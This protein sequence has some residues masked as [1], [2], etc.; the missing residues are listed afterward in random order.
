VIGQG[1]NGPGAWRVATGMTS[2]HTISI[3]PARRRVEIS[4]GGVKLADSDRAVLLEETGIRARYYLPRADVRTEYLRPTATK[5]TCPFKGE[6]SYWSL[7]LDGNV[8]EDLVWSYETPIP[9]AAGIAGLMCFYA[10]RV[11]QQLSELG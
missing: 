4:V 1:R 11:D 10:E 5:T 9:E 3:S 8:H 2:G 7:D 6:A